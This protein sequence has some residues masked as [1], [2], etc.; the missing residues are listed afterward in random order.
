MSIEVTRA[1]LDLFVEGVASSISTATIQI[2]AGRGTDP[3]LPVFVV[4][5]LSEGLHQPGL[6]QTSS[7]DIPIRLSYPLHTMDRISGC[8]D[9]GDRT[10]Q[11]P[12]NG[13]AIITIHG[14]HFGPSLSA[15]ESLNLPPINVTFRMTHLNEDGSEYNKVYTALLI[16][17]TDTEITAKLPQVDSSMYNVPVTITIGRSTITK[18]LLSFEG[19]FAIDGQ[20]KL[21]SKPNPVPTVIEGRSASLTHIPHGY[22]GV[23]IC[24]KGRFPAKPSVGPA[25]LAVQLGLVHWMNNPRSSQWN[26]LWITCELIHHN[27]TDLECELAPG[28]AQGELQMRITDFG[29]DNVLPALDRLTFPPVS[30]VPYSLRAPRSPLSASE[31]GVFTSRYSLGTLL[32]LNVINIPLAFLPQ[33][34]LQFTRFDNVTQTN[35][36]IPCTNLELTHGWGD[37]SLPPTEPFPDPLIRQY[38]ITCRMGRGGGSNYIPELSLTS[39]GI[40][41][42]VSSPSDS[43]LF[44]Y[45]VKAPVLAAIK[46]GPESGGCKQ[47]TGNQTTGS[48]SGEVGGESG[49]SQSN[50]DLGSRITSLSIYDCPTSGGVTITL[51]GHN[52]CAGEPTCLQSV[53]LGGAGDLMC[54]EVADIEETTL[55]CVLPPGSGRRYPVVTVLDDTSSESTAIYI[56]YASPRITRVHGCNNQDTAVGAVECHFPSSFETGGPTLLSKGG[57]NDGIGKVKS[58]NSGTQARLTI[59]GENFGPSGAQ[60]FIGAYPCSDVV[61]DA[62]S[63]HTLLTCVPPP[64]YSRVGLQLIVVTPESSTAHEAEESVSVSFAQ[65]PKGYIPTA[66][67]SLCH[68]CSK[69]FYA[70]TSASFLSSTSPTT[71]ESTIECRPCP[72][73][74]FSSSP[75]SDSCELCPQGTFNP[76]FAASTCQTCPSATFS[77]SPGAISCE[78]CR[79]GETNDTDSKWCIPC[80]V[81]QGFGRGNS[82]C[83]LCPNGTYSTPTSGGICQLCPAG[84]F[85]N[86]SSLQHAATVGDG[87]NAC[88]AC[89]KGT[90]SANPGAPSCSPCS[91]GTYADIEGSLSCTPCVFGTAATSTGSSSCNQCSA[92]SVSFLSRFLIAYQENSNINNVAL[93]TCSQ[94]VQGK[95]APINGSAECLPCQR[96]RYGTI[97]GAELCLPCDAGKYTPYEGN[98]TCFSCE[99]GRY[100]T[101]EMMQSGGAT[102]C[103]NCPLG[104]VA[105]NHGNSVCHI[106]EAGKYSDGIAPDQPCASCPRNSYSSER[107]SSSCRPCP[108]GTVTP[109]NSEGH[110]GCV[111]CDPGTYWTSSYTCVTAD[112]GRHVPEAGASQSFDCP[113]GTFANVTGLSYCYA[114][115]AGKASG[116]GATSCDICPAGRFAREQASECTTCSL[117]SYTPEPGMSSCE[118]CPAGKLRGLNAENNP[119]CLDCPAGSYSNQAGSEL[120]SLCPPGTYSPTPSSS[121]CTEC[122]LGKTSNGFGAT[123]C[124]SCAIGTYTMSSGSTAETCNPCEAGSWTNS[125]GLSSCTSCDPG[126]YRPATSTQGCAPCSPGSY[127]PRP[128]QASC[129]PCARGRYSPARGASICELCAP[130]KYSVGQGESFC[131]PCPSGSHSPFSASYECSACPAG[132]YQ[133]DEEQSSCLPC[134][135]GTFS[136]NPRSPS[137]SPCPLGTYASEPGQSTCIPCNPGYFA[138]TTS[139]H[140]CYSCEPGTAQPEEGKDHCIA[141]APGSSSPS[142]GTACS[143]CPSG[144]YAKEA[145]S[146]LCDACPA[147]KFSRFPNATECE[148]C[149]RGSIQ[150]N[151]AEV[152]CISCPDGLAANSSGLA[153]CILCPSPLVP[154]F[155]RADRC[156]CSQGYYSTITRNYTL[157]SSPFMSAASSPSSSFFSRNSFSSIPQLSITLG[158]NFPEDCVRC[159]SGAICTSPDLS[160]SLL[161]TQSAYWRVSDL[162]HYFYRCPDPDACLGGDGAGYCAPN[163]DGVLCGLCTPGHYYV[164]G[165]CVECSSDELATVQ[166]VMVILAFAIASLAFIW[167]VAFVDRPV[168]TDALHT[169]LREAVEEANAKA[170]LTHRFATDD[171]TEGAPSLNLVSTPPLGPSP[172]PLSIPTS[173]IKCNGQSSILRQGQD[174][175]PCLRSS[176]NDFMMVVAPLDGGIVNGASAENGQGESGWWN[177]ASID[178]G[179]RIGRSESVAVS[180]VPGPLITAAREE[181]SRR[182]AAHKKHLSK[183]KPSSSIPEEKDNEADSSSAADIVKTKVGGGKDD[184]KGGDGKQEEFIDRRK[185]LEQRQLQASSKEEGSVPGLVSKFKIVVGW[186]QLVAVFI[187]LPEIKWE[188]PVMQ[189]GNALSVFLFT[190]SQWAGWHCFYEDTYYSHFWFTIGALLILTAIVFLAFTLPLR[191]CCSE[192]IMIAK[193]KPSKT[194][195]PRLTLSSLPS[196]EKGIEMTSLSQSPSNP[197]S[198]PSTTSPPTTAS[199]TLNKQS[200][201]PPQY[202]SAQRTKAMNKI[203]LAQTFKA[204]QIVF[205]VAYPRTCLAFMRFFSCRNVEGVDL[206]E[207]HLAS[208]CFDDMWYTYLPLI[209]I[210]TLLI[211]LGIPTLYYFLL[212]SRSR[213][214]TLKHPYVALSLGFLFEGYRQEVWWF[215]LIDLTV[216][217]L[218]C[219]ITPLLP[220]PGQLPFATAII[221]LFAGVIFVIAPYRRK[222]DDALHLYALMSLIVL[223]LT[224]QIIYSEVNYDSATINLNTVTLVI[225]LSCVV[226]YFLAQLL[227]IARKHCR[228]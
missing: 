147:G 172:S 64:M 50:V 48:H 5:T 41:K 176:Q 191:L 218:I 63:P 210:L 111:G 223:G 49:T 155:P 198:S 33:V 219:G 28:V 211:L 220:V 153:Q 55:T 84:R 16:S 86:I 88:I 17:N 136:S 193:Q 164:A 146:V 228:R 2:P 174:G 151:S 89:P 137:C 106:C 157:L 123:T 18:S 23:R 215:D 58:L 99:P 222:G 203:L 107:G 152:R 135:A 85:S 129:T 44:N 43:N 177:R 126:S 7:M 91:T 12:T 139:L 19:Y 216:K 36:S 166:V 59:E 124:T 196:T 30:I 171:L 53:R 29:V 209:L 226:L 11:C 110:S 77:S 79:Y 87:L 60:V 25:G 201:L 82:G 186:S 181:A 184:A 208:S 105:T 81:S 179:I 103:L 100:S 116:L 112:L 142:R 168:V 104:T 125:T 182:E 72:P 70:A 127:S 143:P 144:R 68:P 225:M 207:A 214:N 3:L 32:S 167:L 195:V 217:F 161:P 185:E 160:F 9:I 133:P 199:T 162:S 98:L 183:K 14:K 206:I 46:A 93:P 71:L 227:H 74:H 80:P 165:S 204:L 154:S 180:V 158:D 197:C 57:D 169:L 150:P 122:E 119:D 95:Y 37:P 56:Q 140:E 35:L 67:S 66:N 145:R 118:V 52:F 42:V 117:G 13:T 10:F 159:P 34:S 212:R 76:N 113:A 163:H 39:Y 178:G 6:N 134:P 83:Q 22:G 90:Y 102:T 26:N 108:P 65:C 20:T 173:L 94:C 141:C 38:T 190:V 62:L 187:M 121:F 138:N 15:P 73:G 4:E 115:A 194:F 31:N 101:L 109:G 45:P 175:S 130:G 120:C 47:G 192:R 128:G 8:L 148:S 24:A 75:A 170:V 213:A 92:G 205:F 97:R 221:C 149:P 200:A 202:T 156:V 1:N 78:P 27:E 54:Q 51:V 40:D 188:A 96:G 69:G 224:G 21:C 131:P 114:C 132:T 61:H 189:V